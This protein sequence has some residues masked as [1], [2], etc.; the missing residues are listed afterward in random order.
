MKELFYE[1]I[2]EAKE[3]KISLEDEQFPIAFNTIIYENQQVKEQLF[4]DNNL[5]TLVIKNE[6]EFFKYLEAYI[7]LEL[8]ANRKAISFYRD[9]KYYHKKLLLSYLLVNATTEDFLNP[10]SLIKRNISFIKDETFDY[11]KNGLQID[12]AKTFPNSR[13][14]IKKTSQS[15]LMETPNKLEFSLIKEEDGKQLRY[16][17]PEI[18]YGITTNNTG[19]KECYIYSILNPKSKET[20]EEEKHYQKKVARSLYQ[21]NQ[22]IIEQESKEYLDYK[23][24]ESTYYP[25]NISDVSPSAVM[26]LVFMF[27]L[28][29]RENI[30]IVKGIPY[31]PIRY[32]SR[33]LAATRC[34][35]IE[36]QELL[37]QRNQAIQTNITNKFI[38]TF[39]RAAYHMKE[40]TV[41]AYPYDIDEFVHLNIKSNQE[42]T[43][44]PILVEAVEGI[45]KS[46]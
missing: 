33:E 25:E 46:R 12:V 34:E 17:L 6:S 26:S 38:R 29:Q 23:N 21:L 37:I 2:Q 31:L 42:K 32:H 45:R 24:N 22:G 8:K 7:Q 44:N 4:S 30:H 15:V 41:T 1:L 11:L 27:S 43:N 18:S 14:E 39:R 3:G 13:L 20:S 35:D 19:E 9:E 16:P 28:L 40:V 10:I 5:A 36:K